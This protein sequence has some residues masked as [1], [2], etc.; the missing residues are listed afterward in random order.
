MFKNQ[1]LGNYLDNLSSSKPTP[2]GG[3]ASAI[4]AAQAIALLMM[5]CNLTI[6]KKSF[7]EY[8]DE[9]GI[10]LGLLKKYQEEAMA[11]AEDDAMVFNTVMA[12][13]KVG[14]EE[15]LQSALK[16]ASIPPT[17]LLTLAKKVQLVSERIAPITNKNVTSDI[18]VADSLL[19]SVVEC[20]NINIDVNLNL[21][22]DDDFKKSIRLIDR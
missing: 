16:E 19:R 20:A 7:K 6:G 14:N 13:Y 21:I 10:S 4:I 2:G 9:V 3:S 18:Y 12:A 11:L 1:L 17:M 8:E 15:D 22:K 5:V